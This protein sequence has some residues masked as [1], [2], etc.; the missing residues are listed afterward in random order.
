MLCKS[1][2]LTLFSNVGFWQLHETLEPK[3]PSNVLCE[4]GF[5]YVA[6]N[7]CLNS[8]FFAKVSVKQVVLKNPLGTI[9]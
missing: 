6:P 1:V 7:P 8:F 3:K 5:M 4:E 2:K 9:M